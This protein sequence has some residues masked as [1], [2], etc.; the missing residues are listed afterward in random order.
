MGVAARH[1]AARRE[2]E[3]PVEHVPAG[4]R[5][6]SQNH[7]LLAAERVHDE[8]WLGHRRSWLAFVSAESSP[9]GY[10]WDHDGDASHAA[11]DVPGSRRPAE[12]SA[13][14][15]WP[16]PAALRVDLRRKQPC[17][18]VSHRATRPGTALT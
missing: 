6:A 4:L 13:V 3:L 14:V 16:G 10:R 12:P 15:S 1:P 8:V 18:K 9:R 17:A 2:P 7:Y 11:R 5:G